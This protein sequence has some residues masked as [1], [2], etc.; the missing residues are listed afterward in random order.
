MLMLGKAAKLNQR[1]RYIFVNFC[2]EENL[3]NKVFKE[4][5]G[6]GGYKIIDGM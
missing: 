1:F 5:D 2:L 3:S 4:I 6:Q